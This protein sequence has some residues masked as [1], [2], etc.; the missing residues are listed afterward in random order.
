MRLFGKK[1]EAEER[2]DRQFDEDEDAELE[3]THVG[4]YEI[5]A[6]VGAGGMGTVYKAI[7]RQRDQTVAIKVLDKEYDLDPQQRR[8]D[9]LGREI[10]IAASLQHDCVIKMHKQVIEQADRDG[11]IRR[12]LLMEYIDGHNLRKHIQERDLGLQQMVNVCIRLARGID[13]LHQNGIVHRDIKPENF[14][15]SRDLKQVKIADFGLSKSSA[16][17]R[18]RWLKERGGT[19]RYM[20]PEQMAKKSLDARSDIFSFGITMYEL[21]TGH[22]PCT[23]TDGK[24]MLRQLRSSKYKFPTPSKYNPEISPALDRIIL[25]SMRRNPERRYQS[26]TEMLMDLTRLGESRI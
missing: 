25:K 8:K 15:F 16:S 17:W 9:Y 12:C 11:N 1:K 3:L 5:L 22:H 4:P 20:S 23:A 24:E 14:L 6:P 18:T 21:F 10:L 26:M 19:R 2:E 7:D 13:F